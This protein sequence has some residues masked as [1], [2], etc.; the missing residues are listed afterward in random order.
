VQ[1]DPALLNSIGQ[2]GTTL[3]PSAD[4][5]VRLDRP[6]KQINNTPAVAAFPKTNWLLPAN[7]GR[8]QPLEGCRNAAV[9][10]LLCWSQRQSAEA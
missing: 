6:K 2:I 3:L 1:P 9:G 8:S 10:N 4:H 7:N 5:E